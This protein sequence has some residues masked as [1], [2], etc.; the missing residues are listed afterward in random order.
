LEI[1]LLF[2]LAALLLLVN[3]PIAVSLGISAVATIWIFGLAPLNLVPNLAYATVSKFTLLAVP[4]F[5]AAG[6]LMERSGIAHRL[7]HFSELLVGKLRGGLAYVT[8]VVAIFFAGIS[9]SGTADTA[10][11]GA[12]LLPSMERTG[13]R[14]E[15]AAALVAAGGAIGIIVPPSITYVLYGAISGASIGKLFVAGIV[16]GILIGIALAVPSFFEARRSD[17]STVNRG[18]FKE[19]MVATRRASWGIAAPIIILGGIY[20]GLF[21]PTEAAGIVVVYAVIVGM[22]IY[23]ELKP[24]T[25][26]NV[27]SEAALVTGMAL[28]IVIGASLFSW[29][30]TRL[31]L[32]ARVAELVTSI[33]TDPVLVVFLLLVILLIVGMVLDAISITFV[34]IPIFLP[35]LQT[36]GIDLV[37]FGVLFTV[38]MAIGQITPPMGVNLF[39]SAGIANARF[40]GVA[41]AAVPMVGAQIV[42]L[43]LLVLIPTLTLGL[44]SLLGM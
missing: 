26:V 34:F 37:W 38:V 20:S 22:L 24:S 31:G 42:V 12:I 30:V 35:L 16:P 7:V 6:F 13:Y 44:P 3:V 39:I 40:A 4:Y 9:G 32:S 27:F 5:I 17:I 29:V 8:I 41:R 33:T 28:T 14:K 15:F 1:I 11:L 43:I 18:S 2:G 25:L 10:A 36:A 23:R 19:V 21:T